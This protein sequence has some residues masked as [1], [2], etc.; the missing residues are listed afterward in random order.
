M[1]EIVIDTSTNAEGE[2]TFSWSVWDGDQQ[3]EIDRTTH[4]S[5]SDC[6]AHAADF[7]WRTLGY[8]PDK[9]TRL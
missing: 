3:I 4:F 7:C 8:K 2:A 1:I 5:A 9:V 6:E